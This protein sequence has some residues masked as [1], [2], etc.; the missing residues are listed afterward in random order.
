MK[1]II[2]RSRYDTDHKNNINIDNNS[3][4]YYITII[5]ASKG[6]QDPIGSGGPSYVEYGLCPRDKT[7]PDEINVI[8][9]LS[10]AKLFAFDKDTHG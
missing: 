1:L 7:F 3:C 9:K 5:T 6:I 10:F 2:R 4:Y 8:R